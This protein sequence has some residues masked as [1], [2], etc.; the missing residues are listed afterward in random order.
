MA[1]VPNAE[2]L[3]WREYCCLTPP[4]KENEAQG[5]KLC[6]QVAQAVPRTGRSVN[7]P[8]GSALTETSL[9]CLVWFFFPCTRISRVFFSSAAGTEGKKQP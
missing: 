2:R 6:C 1:S 3:L 4:G 7:V 9:T 5:F 8:G